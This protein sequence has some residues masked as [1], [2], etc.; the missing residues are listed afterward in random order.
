MGLLQEDAE[1][2]FAG[3]PADDGLDANEI[4]AMLDSRREARDRKDFAEAD[5]IRDELQARG[6]AI[7]DGPDGTQ[8]RRQ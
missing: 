5:R 1:A 2:W 8:W 6:I 4:E 3:S 7:E